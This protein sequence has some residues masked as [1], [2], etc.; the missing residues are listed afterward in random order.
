[1]VKGVGERV[2]LVEEEVTQFE[3]VVHEVVL[4]IGYHADNIADVQDR[5]DSLSQAV[6]FL[7][8]RKKRFNF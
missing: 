2:K 8:F 1:M 5:V 4:D 3:G 7:I 6:P